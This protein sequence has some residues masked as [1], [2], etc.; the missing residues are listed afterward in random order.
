M[1]PHLLILIAFLLAPTPP[2]H[3]HDVDRLLDAIRRVETGH[4]P[5]QGDGAR[6]DWGHARGPFQIHYSY[7]RD[8]G[9]PG[10][11]EDC[12][13]LAYSRRVVLAYWRRYCPTAL[14]LRDAQTLAR[15]HNGG[16]SGP[17]SPSTM[18]YWLRVQ[19]ALKNPA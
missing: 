6:G 3:A 18:Q 14:K 11:Y 19:K 2:T 1:K 7:W 4:H 12:D 15:I 8:S 10:H 5:R 16:P 17:H 9:L 13:H